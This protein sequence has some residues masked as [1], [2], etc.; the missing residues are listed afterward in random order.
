MQLPPCPPNLEME[1]LLYPDPRLTAKNLLL[2]SWS[3]EA[4]VQVEEMRKLL[5]NV[6]GAGLAAPQ[7]G[8]NVRLFIAYLRDEE[9]GEE[10]EQVIFD[11]EISRL[12]ELVSMEEGCLSFPKIRAKI[13][14]YDR[15]RL[16]GKTPQG[17][18]DRVL[19]GFYAQVVQH[20][21]DHLD[22]LLFIE[23]MSPI[24]RS[25]WASEIKRMEES[26]EKRLRG[27]AQ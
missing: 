4:H 18:I 2:G 25:S 24:Y 15:V 13:L 3:P 5:E 20:E 1:I 22:G 16:V 23:K 11:P 8:W 26:F 17:P 10:V 21:M 12:G 27:K 19:T 14:R 6:P 9:S 7:V